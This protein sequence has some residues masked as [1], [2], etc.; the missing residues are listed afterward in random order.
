MVGPG[1]PEK[2]RLWVE[3]RLASWQ[4]SGWGAPPGDTKEEYAPLEEYA[5]R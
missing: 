3:I 4:T 2:E 1:A 5:A